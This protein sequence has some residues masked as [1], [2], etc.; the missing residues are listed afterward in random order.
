MN[1]G[2][3]YYA[4]L[5]RTNEAIALVV[6]PF[7]GYRVGD[8]VLARKCESKYLVCLPLTIPQ[9]KEA[10]KKGTGDKAWLYVADIPE[11]NL[12]IVL[13]ENILV[14]GHD[15]EWAEYINRL[16]KKHGVNHE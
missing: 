10:D 6:E 3:L 5:A 16:K 11:S 12:R 2:S 14:P 1:R 13:D 9:L 7:P 15:A 4:L 8:F